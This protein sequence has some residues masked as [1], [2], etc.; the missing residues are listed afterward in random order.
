MT[1]NSLTTISDIQTFGLWK[2]L[3]LELFFF[4]CTLFLLRYLP[5]ACFEL[6]KTPLISLKVG[7]WSA[8][9]LFYQ[10]IFG[11][12]PFGHD[13]TQERILRDDNYKSLQG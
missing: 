8:G 3:S 7:V 4:S 13:L 10:M 1:L 12:R 11:R 5:P 6:N 9:V 2:P